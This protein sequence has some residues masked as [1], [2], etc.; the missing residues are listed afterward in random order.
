MIECTALFVDDDELIRRVTELGLSQLV[1]S[2][3]CV[4]SSDEAIDALNRK[5]FDVVITDLRMGGDTQDA[6]AEGIRLVRKIKQ[7]Y[8]ETIVILQ[9]GYG[10]LENAEKALRAGAFDFVEKPYKVER[11]ALVIERALESLR[12]SRELTTLRQQVAFE[13]SFDNITGSSVSM[14]SLRAEITRAA[15]CDQP[16]LIFG[17]PGSGKNMIAKTIHH[18]SRRR[19]EVVLSFDCEKA[20]KRLIDSELFGSPATSRAGSRRSGLISQASCG[21]LILRHVDTLPLQSRVRLL[22][23]IRRREEGTET[24]AN[25]PNVDVRI[26]MTTTATRAELDSS[27]LMTEATMDSLGLI[28]LSAI[29][30]RERSEDIPA[31]AQKIMREKGEGENGSL[32]Q[33]E[34]RLSPAALERMLDYDWPGN[35]RELQNVIQR[36]KALAT[37]DTISP[38]D[39]FFTQNHRDAQTTAGSRVMGANSDTRSSLE[40]TYRTR[41]LKSLED[42]NWNYSQTAIEL[43][44]GRTTLWRKVKKYNLNKDL[45][46]EAV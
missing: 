37:N 26:I 6:D 15:E 12:M 31:L 42:N 21:T 20:P 41:I 23:M 29:A 16:I 45:I 19:R 9:T 24:T 32:N 36:A 18:H 4:S 27:G 38:D 28:S 3:E 33:R 40:M 1:K 43:G 2:V 8:P 17:E 25:N 39:V 10:T 5:H 7:S 46:N 44:I 11:L 14:Q 34:Y 35:V 13:F 30:L 22:D